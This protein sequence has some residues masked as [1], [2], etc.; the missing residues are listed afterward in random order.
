MSGFSTSFFLEG[1][2][3]TKRATLLGREY[4]QCLIYG[5]EFLQAKT[6]RSRRTCFEVHRQYLSRM[7][8]RE[9]EFCCH[10]QWG[11]GSLIVGASALWHQGPLGRYLILIREISE[12]KFHRPKS[13]RDREC[14]N[15]RHHSVR[16]KRVVEP[17]GLYWVA[18]EGS[19][20][21]CGA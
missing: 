13:G 6:G 4:G 8:K 3:T 12:P 15:A 20:E 9:G 7:S 1:F 17:N 19:R 16:K 10:P 21:L 11:T 18:E 2:V 14:Y 5:A